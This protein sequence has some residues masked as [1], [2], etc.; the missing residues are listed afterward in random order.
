LVSST[1]HGHASIK[2]I[3]FQS[4]KFA[5]GTILAALTP[6]DD[7]ALSAKFLYYYLSNFKDE[8]IVP[9]MKGMAN[10][11]LSV[12]RLKTIPIIVPPIEKQVEIVTFMEKCEGLRNI[13]EK[14][15]QDAESM[16]FAS[17]S[18]VFSK[19]KG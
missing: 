9:L 14:S 8:L 11:T 7:K 5:L 1:G 4:G 6:K 3:Q 16:I 19:D 17:L 10:V 15:K 12:T 18:E 2:R 13:L